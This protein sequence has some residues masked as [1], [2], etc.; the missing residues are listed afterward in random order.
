M[1]KVSVSRQ[2]ISIVQC[3]DCL[4]ADSIGFLTAS[5]IFS[6]EWDGLKK[7]VLFYY[8]NDEPI[9]QVLDE[10]NEMEVPWEVIKKPGFKMSIIGVHE[11][12]TDEVSTRRLTTGTVFVKINQSGL[13]EYGEPK[14]PSL[15]TYEQIVAKLGAIEESCT[16]LV[17]MV[18]DKVI[19]GVKFTTDDAG[20]ITGGVVTYSDGTT[21]EVP[22][23][24][25]T[26]TDPDPDTG[27]DEPTDEPT[28]D[29]DAEQGE[30]DGTV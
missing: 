21:E 1:I 20:L 18:P 14:A 4:V 2:Q 9:G 26:V 23:E 24:Q 3:P 11:S 28:D 6:D 10:T 16:K 17:G 13:S 29:P 27:E 25:E 12:D 30:D 8:D 22:V 5:F 19:T 7:T 15:G